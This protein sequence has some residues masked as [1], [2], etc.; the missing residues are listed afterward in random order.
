MSAVG[1]VEKKMA[2]RYAAQ[3]PSY[4]ARQEELGLP[5]PRKPKAKNTER[6]LDG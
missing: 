3:L 5:A 2:A 1:G 6:Y 4:A